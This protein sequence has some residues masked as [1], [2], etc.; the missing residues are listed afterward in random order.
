MNG[1][2]SDSGLRNCFLIGLLMSLTGLWPTVANGSIEQAKLILNYQGR[3][4]DLG[5]GVG[6]S[7]AIVKRIPAAKKNQVILAGNSSGSVL[8]SYFACR[9]F[10]TD[11]VE[12]LIR[13]LVKT[14]P[15]CIN[16][17]PKTKFL[18]ISTGLSDTEYPLKNLDQFIAVALS[19]S[20]DALLPQ[21]MANTKSKSKSEFDFP[22]DELCAPVLPLV[23]TAANF[24]VLDT[25]Q[26]GAIAGRLAV[27]RMISGI[28]PVH[29]KLFNEDNFAVSWKPEKFKAMSQA[30]PQLS[31]AYIGKACTYFAT[32]DAFQVMSQ[33][34][35]EER[36]CDLRLIK[37]GRDLRLAIQASSAEPTYFYPIPEPNLSAI[38]DSDRAQ[39][40]DLAKRSYS[41][42]FLVPTVAQDIRRVM[43]NLYVLGTGWSPLM[44]N[45][46]I[47]IRE[48][49]L[50][51]VFT[52]AQLTEWWLD[53]S[54]IPPKSLEDEMMANRSRPLEAR[55]EKLQQYAIDSEKLAHSCFDSGNC[56]PKFIKRP[57]YYKTLK[58]NQE[59]VAQRGLSALLGPN[60]GQDHRLAK[61][62]SAD[63]GSSPSGITSQ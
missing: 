30:N 35:Y 20:F 49:Q 42:G 59:L 47:L 61:G 1:N 37:D 23:I 43:S 14:D 10:S 29:A 44:G 2:R 4:T 63:A 15:A 60:Q 16:E 53:T 25:R 58:G 6:I 56:H 62:T 45:A 34:P 55:M 36:L 28:A 38:L 39:V 12:E 27:K 52:A 33:I 11:T 21:I 54:L 3:G 26:R 31:T 22:E 18:A 7:R 24:E 48:W 57:K 13:R 51:D 9:G 50:V 19:K 5:W 41:G 40:Q 32:A 46:Q 8:A 17:D